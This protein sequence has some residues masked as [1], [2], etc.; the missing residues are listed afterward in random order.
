[1]KVDAGKDS[2]TKAAAE[3]AEASVPCSSTRTIAWWNTSPRN[4]GVRLIPEKSASLLKAAPI[5]RLVRAFLTLK[6]APD[7]EN[8]GSA[9]NPVLGCSLA[10]IR[11][12]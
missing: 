10:R 6:V 2:S 4:S 7:T 3:A 8:R 5:P 1:L 9:R 11:S 12:S